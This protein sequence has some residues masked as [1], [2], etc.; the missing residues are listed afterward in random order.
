[1]LVV[2]GRWVFEHPAVFF[3]VL[4]SIHYTIPKKDCNYAMILGMADWMKATVAS[5]YPKIKK[6]D[7]SLLF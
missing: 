5:V 4:I 1:M 2:I 3:Y 6:E 7:R